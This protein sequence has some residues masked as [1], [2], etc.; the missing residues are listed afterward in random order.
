[1]QSAVEE[2]EEPQPKERTL[3]GLKLTDGLGIAEPGI[4]VFEN[5]G[6]NEE[7][8]ATTGQGTIMMLA[9][10]EEILKKKNRCLS[11]H[12]SR[13]DFFTSHSRTPLSAPTLLGHWR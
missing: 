9:Y 11:R 6:W 8:V 13:P 3:N 1:M 4:K 2:A 12:T 5:T 7:R 10:Y